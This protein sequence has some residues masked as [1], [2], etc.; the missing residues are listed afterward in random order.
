MA[1]FC[2]DCYNKLNDTNYSEAQVELEMDLCEGCGEWK[3][4]VV[5]FGKPSVWKKTK[6]RIYGW[7]RCCE[8]KFEKKN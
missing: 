6:N 8:E 3:T 5:W 7:L 1:E 4:V 2:L